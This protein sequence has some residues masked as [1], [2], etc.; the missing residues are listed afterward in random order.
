ME[1]TQSPPSPTP[2]NSADLKSPWT[3]QYGEYDVANIM[4]GLSICAVI[5][6]SGYATVVKGQVF[7]PQ[8][9][10]VGLASLITALGVYRWGDSKTKRPDDGH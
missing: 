8:A 7:D 1:T 9:L 4:L 3:D 5:G 10:G 6:L 2:T